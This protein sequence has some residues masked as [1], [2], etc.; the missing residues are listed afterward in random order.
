ML[1]DHEVPTFGSLG[2]RCVPDVAV[3]HPGRPRPPEPLDLKRRF[4]GRLRL[5]H[6]PGQHSES[7][8]VLN[9]RP[10]GNAR[11]I[12]DRPK[13]LGIGLREEHDARIRMQKA[14]QSRYRACLARFRRHND[15][16][17]PRRQVA[18]PVEGVHGDPR[19]MEARLPKQTR[20]DRIPGLSIAG[21]HDDLQFGLLR[22]VSGQRSVRRPSDDGEAPVEF[23]LPKNL[24]H[25]LSNRSGFRSLSVRG[26]LIDQHLRIRLRGLR[27]QTEQVSSARAN[28]Q[29]PS[30]HGE[31]PGLAGDFETPD[32]L[33]GARVIG[34]HHSP[35]AQNEM[36]RGQG[37]DIHL[38][39]LVLRD[40]EAAP[41]MA[42]ERVG[43]VRGSELAEMVDR[44]NALAV[45][46]GSVS[47]AVTQEALLGLRAGRELIGIEPIELHGIEFPALRQGREGTARIRVGRIEEIVAGDGRPGAAMAPGPGGPQ[48]AV[49]QFA[50]RAVEAGRR[51]ASGRHHE[52]IP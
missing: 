45:R 15:V 11:L 44:E 17:K 32:V 19:A 4:D 20:T 8:R 52:D 31:S 47:V 26:I 29:L 51:T 24:Q 7:P 38:R 28:D 12:E 35:V 40:P 10:L 3:G 21:Q 49:E 25:G 43:H 36:L 42:I 27:A 9:P 6:R 34:P 1:S 48:I 22:K 23:G 41:E 33:T 30:G 13:L 46:Q 37:H 50:G 2:A 16:R 39:A 14:G 5:R 18:Q